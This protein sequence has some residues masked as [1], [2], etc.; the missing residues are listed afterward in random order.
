MKDTTKDLRNYLDGAQLHTLEASFRSWAQASKRSD[1]RLSRQRILI[2]FL[3][4]RYTAAKLNEVLS[5]VPARDIDSSR[6]RISFQAETGEG[7]STGRNVPISEQ[8]AAELQEI[9]NLAGC[10]P[11]QNSL[12]VDPAFVRRKFYERAQGCGFD[13]RLGGPEM[14]RGARAAELMRGNLPMP[15]VQEMLG[16]SSPSLTSAYVT[17]TPAE[18]DQVTRIYIEREAGRKTSARNSFFGKIRTIQKGDIQASVTLTTLSGNAITTMITMNSLE[19]LGL[20]EGQLITAEVKA[21]WVILQ[22]SAG[23]PDSSADNALCGVIQGINVGQVNSEYVL[24]LAD[25]TT[26]CAVI[27][28]ATSKELGLSSGDEVWALFNCYG[29]VLHLD[30]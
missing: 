10:A 22:K 13:K 14:I 6:L 12:D 17:F 19:S 2:I 20:S 5:L 28:S 7:G 16:Q 11:L 29:V 1:V 4:I 26:L 8:L 30:G 21:P 27:S 18:I 9:F 3:V 15:A 24:K 25:G 23:Q